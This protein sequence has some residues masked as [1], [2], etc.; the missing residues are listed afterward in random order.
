MVRPQLL[1]QTILTSINIRRT[2][3]HWH[4]LEGKGHTQSMAMV[5]SR[6]Q[7][8]WS[9]R[10]KLLHESRHVTWGELSLWPFAETRPSNFYY[11]S[12]LVRALWLANFAG[13]ILLY[14]P[15]FLKQ[16]PLFL[17]Q[18]R[19][20]HWYQFGAK[21]APVNFRFIY[22]LSVTTLA[23]S[24]E[25]SNKNDATGIEEFESLHGEPNSGVSDDESDERQVIKEI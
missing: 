5:G 17:K 14:C 6:W 7:Y 18:L 19:V 24:D 11:I 9:S 8:N 12:L 15:L 3:S 1:G 10:Q 2:T 16:L 23:A 4:F 21:S 22:F 25:S 13:R 20:L